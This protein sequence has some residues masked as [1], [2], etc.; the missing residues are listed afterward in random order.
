MALVACP[1]CNNEIA[2]NA[3]DCPKCGASIRKP[4][5][6]FFG[7]IVKWSFVAFNVI[8]LAMLVTG[9]DGAA[10]KSGTLTSDAEQAG[11]AIGTAIGATLVIGI[12]VAGD[13]I[14]GLIMLFTRPSKS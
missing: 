13:I 8:M 2:E 12:W 5:R 11:A 9:L 7:K 10:D 14:L 4:T 6:S 1:E 3:Y